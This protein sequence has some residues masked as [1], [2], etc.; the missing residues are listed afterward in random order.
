MIF[1]GISPLTLRDCGCHH[2][3]YVTECSLSDSCHLCYRE[4]V[5]ATSRYKQ[6]GNRASGAFLCC[7]TN[8][9]QEKRNCRST[10]PESLLKPFLAVSGPYVGK[11][12]NVEM[13][14]A[15]RPPQDRRSIVVR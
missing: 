13:E 9:T 14:E 12:T 6:N 4:I 2:T 3:E 11:P 1:N 5:V 8:A 10:Y 7:V 15:A